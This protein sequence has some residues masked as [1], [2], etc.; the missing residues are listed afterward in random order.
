M[1]YYNIQGLQMPDGNTYEF[2]GK[3]YYGT[4]STAGTTQTKAVSINGFDTNSLV[5]GMRVVVCFYYAQ[6]Y[7]GVP[8]LNIGGTGAKAIY[9][10]GGQNFANINEWKA[11][12]VVSFIY[13][14]SAWYIENSKR[15]STYVNDA[16]FLTLA[17][18]P[19]YDG[20]VTG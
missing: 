19:I 6:L 11:Y 16:G 7:N 12:D 17:D 4:C 9:K 5:K 8:F 14:G 3:T 15:L 10:N 18:L 1:A 2:F 20:S 13:N